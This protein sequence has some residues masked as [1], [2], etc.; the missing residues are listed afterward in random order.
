MLCVHAPEYPLF[1]IPSSLDL[2]FHLMVPV[3][4]HPN[5]CILRGTSIIVA[6]SIV[7]LVSFTIKLILCQQENLNW[8]SLDVDYRKNVI[9]LFPKVNKYRGVVDQD[10]LSSSDII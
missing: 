5:Q 4:L 7:S 1:L 8:C 9:V 6:S 2:M 10:P 3:L